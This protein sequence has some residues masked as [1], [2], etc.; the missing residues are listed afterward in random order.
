MNDPI[1]S[2]TPISFKIA[3]QS[4]KFAH[5]GKYWKP[6]K[7]SGIAELFGHSKDHNQQTIVVPTFKPEKVALKV[8]GTTYS[9]QELADALSVSLNDFQKK[10]LLSCMKPNDR[11]QHQQQNLSF[12]RFLLP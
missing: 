10:P 5:N 6:K 8:G 11:R 4:G 9:L 1:I 7:D 12:C 2:D 3:E